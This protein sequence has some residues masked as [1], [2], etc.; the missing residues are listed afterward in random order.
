LCAQEEKIV[1][2]GK[3]IRSNIPSREE[4]IPPLEGKRIKSED[5]DLQ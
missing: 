5:D 2:F 4:T 1:K 3:S